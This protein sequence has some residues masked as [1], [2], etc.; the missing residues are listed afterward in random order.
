MSERML[1]RSSSVL[2]AVWGA[3]HI[4]FGIVLL[5]LLQA[6]SVAEAVHGIAGQA[7][8]S[9]L[10]LDYPEGVVAILKQHA[11]NLLWFGVVTLIGSV[12]VWRRSTQAAALCAIVG[13]LY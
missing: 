13:F 2:W 7:E 4:F 3:V 12:W 9:T 11:Y 5:S 10:M 1:F 6:G 8:L